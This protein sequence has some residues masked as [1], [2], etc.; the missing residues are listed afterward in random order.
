MLGRLVL[1][2]FMVTLAVL[3]AFI[4]FI[5]SGVLY[6]QRLECLVC[7]QLCLTFREAFFF[8]SNFPSESIMYQ[9]GCLDYVTSYYRYLDDSAH[10]VLH[11]FWSSVY[12]VMSF[13]LTNLFLHFSCRDSH[14]R[15][16]L[17]DL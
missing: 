13:S 1:K 2:I 17:T 15:L 10:Y 4:S 9:L 11:Y 5:F 16:K 14:R 8:W 6:N 12:S 3:F 7:S